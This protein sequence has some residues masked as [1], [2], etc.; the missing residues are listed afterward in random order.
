MIGPDGKWVGFGLGDCD[1]DVAR[2]DPNW[3]AVTLIREKL[4]AKY[5]W[6]RD[7]GVTPGSTITEIVADAIA[8]FQHRA[9][10]PVLLDQGGHGYADFRTRVRLGSYPPPP[11]PRHALL[12]FRGTGGIVGL[13]YT[14]RVA[15]ANADV[16]EEIP[17]LYPASMGGIPV[18]AA[19]DIN[20]PSG[21]ACVDIAVDMACA[22]IRANPTR[23]FLLGGYSLGAIAASRV[24]AMLLPGG[25]LEKYADNYVAGFALGN[26]ARAFGHTYYLGAIPNGFGISNW[27]LP[28]SACT[29]DWC[30]IVDPDDMYANTHG[31]DVGDIIRTVQEMVMATTVS[32]PVGT[33]A[34]MIP[35]ILQL[36]NEAGVELPFNIP[37]IITGAAAG[38]LAALLPAELA[39]LLGAAGNR[40][41]AAAVQAAI[42]ALRFF[43]SNPPT[44][45]HISYEWREVW[46]GQTYLGLACQHVRDWATK[47][48]VR[49]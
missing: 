22:W 30:E 38:L 21:N 37:G 44:A 12:T 4:T 46:P 28:Q 39:K 18:G 31:G 36:L 33:V 23:T 3:H 11:A 6:A 45:A 2:T 43:A 41:T 26:P 13:D 49:S 40:E 9:G 42:I 1:P 20:A 10:I 47:V 7:M 15:Q 17:I 34:K 32:D 29:W 16:V 5:A 14:S 24:R 19:G 48:P 25:E 8:E 35:L 27:H